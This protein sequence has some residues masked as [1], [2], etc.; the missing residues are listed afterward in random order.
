MNETMKAELSLDELEG[1]AGGDG[2]IG[3][4]ATSD[5]VEL[6]PLPLK[7]PFPKPKGPFASEAIEIAIY[8]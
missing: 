4:L 2:L 6:C 7:F 3:P 1:V 5:D 8:K